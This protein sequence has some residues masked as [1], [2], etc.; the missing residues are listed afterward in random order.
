M[1]GKY[2]TCSVCGLAGHTLVKDG[3]SG[4]KHQN[5]AICK[6]VMRNQPKR[7]LVAAAPRVALPSVGEVMKYARPVKYE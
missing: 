4:Y 6:Q 3:K 1:K 7:R 2:I 5:S